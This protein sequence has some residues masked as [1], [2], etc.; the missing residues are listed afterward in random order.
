M[1]SFYKYNIY[2]YIYIYIYYQLT[3]PNNYRLIHCKHKLSELFLVVRVQRGSDIG[4][5]NFFTSAKL[6][7]LQKWLHLPKNTVWKENTPTYKIIL[8]YEESVRWL[9]RFQQKL[10]ETPESSNIVLE[11]TNIKTTISQA[12]NESFGRYKTFTQKK[13]EKIW[14]YKI[15]LIAQQRIFA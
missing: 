10:Q 6:R 5:D 7:F 12:A 14:V 11:W 13:K 15:K 2:I 9:H 1:N 4:S 8:L 3:I